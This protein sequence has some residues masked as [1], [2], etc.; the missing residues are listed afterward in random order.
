M[1]N[2][3]FWVKQLGYGNYGYWDNNAGSKSKAFKVLGLRLPTVVRRKQR[4]G[5][6]LVEGFYGDFHINTSQAIRQAQ[7]LYRYRRWIAQTFQ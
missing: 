6:L 4:I 2:T 7:R 3:I 1:V 5:T